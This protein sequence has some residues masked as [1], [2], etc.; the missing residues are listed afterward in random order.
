M[1]PLPSLQTVNLLWVWDR[2]RIIHDYFAFVEI[3]IIIIIIIIITI[4][5]ADGGRMGRVFSGVCLFV[6]LSVYFSTRYL[7]NQCS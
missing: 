6:S 5:H 2:C 3:I 7:K 1:Q 4:T